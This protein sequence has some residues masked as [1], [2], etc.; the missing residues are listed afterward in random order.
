MLGQMCTSISNTNPDKFGYR[1]KLEFGEASRNRTWEHRYALSATVKDRLRASAHADKSCPEATHEFVLELSERLRRRQFHC[2]EAKLVYPKEDYPELDLYRSPEDFSEDFG[3]EGPIDTMQD[4]PE[5]KGWTQEEETVDTEEDYSLS[6]G[7]F[8][9]PEFN[10]DSLTY[11]KYAFRIGPSEDLML[12][13][14]FGEAPFDSRSEW[15]LGKENP[16]PG[17]FG[18]TARIGAWKPCFELHPDGHNLPSNDAEDADDGEAYGDDEVHED[19]EI[20]DNSDRG[21]ESEESDDVLSSA[22]RFD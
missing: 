20:D 2:F 4:Y 14:L 12:R 17:T 6:N 10:Q 5:L 15:E 1:R 9:N 11:R 16:S 13:R 19:G 18:Y 8:S 22:N 7:H 3:D 21:S